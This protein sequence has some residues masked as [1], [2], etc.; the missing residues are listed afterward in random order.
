MKFLPIHRALPAAILMCILI[1]GCGGG[2]GGV[3]S[4]RK[5]GTVRFV[6]KWPK[7][8]RSVMRHSGSRVIP[9]SA[10]SINIDVQDLGGKV[11]ATRL[12]VRPDTVT[13]TGQLD[14]TNVPAGNVRVV[15]KA[16]PQTD[17]TGEL[18]A[19]GFVD[20][21]V[22]PS[23]TA[24]A[25]LSMQSTV[26]HLKVF[27]DSDTIKVGDHEII[28]VAAYDA[29]D[30]VVMTDPLDWAWGVNAQKYGAIASFTSGGNLA[31][32]TGKSPG[33]Y[34]ID[35]FFTGSEA[36]QPTVQST[37]TLQIVG[38]GSNSHIII[39]DHGNKRVVGVS[40]MAGANF[41][42]L[43]S[44]VTFYNP[45]DLALD[46]AGNIYVE[47]YYSS[48]AG[49][50][51]PGRIVKLDPNGVFQT[52]L[53]I[54]DPPSALFIDRQNHIY[55]RDDSGYINRVDNIAGANK[56][57]FGG[58]GSGLFGDPIGIA[59]D[60][61]GF[62]YVLDGT[63]NKVV[64]VDNMTGANPVNFGTQGNG[65]NQFDLLTRTH[66]PAPITHSRLIRTTTYMYRTTVTTESWSLMQMH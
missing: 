36:G 50:I 10:T 20:V 17:G 62:I 56:Q 32:I 63:G 28:G 51:H 8:G 9:I 15:A 53:I 43:Q 55:W 19:Q 34:V 60:T 58:F 29:A 42:V 38:V 3:A 41:T 27:K 22:A 5:P 31:N 14:I 2:G 4:S 26:T 37:I 47:E 33:T 46:T 11:L 12:F 6:V 16:Y 40:D 49:G 7:P 52:E 24:T 18:Q 65:R 21:T 44:G 66:T 30:I 13:D 57:R 61:G 45:V 35:A 1:A 25:S 39:L 54:N 59:V 23:Q 48:D 64:R